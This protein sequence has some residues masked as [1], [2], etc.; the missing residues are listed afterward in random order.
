MLILSSA[1]GALWVEDIIVAPQSENSKGPRMLIRPIA[2]FSDISSIGARATPARSRLITHGPITTPHCAGTQHT[3]STPPAEMQITPSRRLG[4]YPYTRSRGTR[5]H[6]LIRHKLRKS[7]AAASARNRW[8]TRPYRVAATTTTALSA[9]GRV[10]PV[11]RWTRAQEITV[12]LSLSVVSIWDR[13]LMITEH[14]TAF[15]ALLR[16]DSSSYAAAGNCVIVLSGPLS[17]AYRRIVKREALSRPSELS[18]ERSSAFVFC[19]W[20]RGARTMTL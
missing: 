10:R 7:G 16:D 8:V 6:H 20:M 11:F 13:K 18:C 5:H 14:T 12:S 2:Q 3:H 1:N 4:A 17:R 9:C 19:G 15:H